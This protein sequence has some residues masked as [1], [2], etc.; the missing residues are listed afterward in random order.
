MEAAICRPG[1]P[2][3][4]TL[5]SINVESRRKYYFFDA[6][7]IE[8]TMPG[9]SG[10]QAPQRLSAGRARGPG[11]HR[12]AAPPAPP[13]GARA[14]AAQPPVTLLRYQNQFPHEKLQHLSASWR[15]CQGSVYQR[16][17]SHTQI[18]ILPGRVAAFLMPAQDRRSGDDI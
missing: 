15:V 2:V 11:A 6:F 18:P 17:N 5:L 16:Q 3:L 12:A 7:L 13:A 14:A 4:D 8:K 1:N 10:P 9:S